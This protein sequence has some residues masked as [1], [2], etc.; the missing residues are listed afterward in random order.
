MGTRNR[1]ETWEE[2]ALGSRASITM[3][4]TTTNIDTTDSGDAT[5]APA[6]DSRPRSTS[7]TPVRR[8]P[9][10]MH[11]GTD[12]PN[13]R[14]VPQSSP[15]DTQ[16]ANNAKPPRLRNSSSSDY[17]DSSH[18]SSDRTRESFVTSPSAFNVI[19]HHSLSAPSSTVNLHNKPTHIITEGTHQIILQKDP[20]SNNY[21]VKHIDEGTFAFYCIRG[22]YTLI[23]ILMSGFLFAFSVQIILFVFLGLLI[24]SGLTDRNQ[25]GFHFIRFICTL[26]ALPYF[27]YGLASAMAMA[28]AFAADTFNGYPLFKA[29]VKEEIA[30]FVDWSS[31][32]V[33]LG[34]PLLTGGVCLCA[35]SSIWWEVTLLTSCTCVFLYF[36]LFAG[37]SIYYEID[38]CLKLQE[39]GGY[40]YCWPKI[41]KAILLRQKQK[42]SGYR[43]ATYTVRSNGDL[44]IPVHDYKELERNEIVN[45][46][47]TIG[48]WARFTKLFVS[49]G[50]YKKLP[51][52]AQVRCFSIDEVLDNLP[53][54]TKHSWG[55]EK[56]FCRNRQLRYV[57]VVSGKSKLTKEQ[58]NSSAAYFFLIAILSLFMMVA[59][60]SWM[61]IGF[62]GYVFAVGVYIYCMW[63]YTAAS[64]RIYKDHTDKVKNVMDKDGELAEAQF[65][66]NEVFL[67]TEP[68]DAFC[69]TQL[70]LKILFLC[71]LPLIAIF[72]A[73]NIPIGIL[74]IFVS[75]ITLL[76]RNIN[77]TTSLLEYGS[78]HSRAI[79]GAP[80]GEDWRQK[81]R[82]Q[83]VVQEISTSS[84][85]G[86]WQNVFTIFIVIFCALFVGA[87]LSPPRQRLDGIKLASNSEYSGATS[88]QY[89]S[90]QLTQGFP[91]LEGTGA[92]LV[93]VAFL[94]TLM[95][96][97]TSAID[98]SLTKWFRD[99]KFIDHSE[100]IAI[101]FKENY[102]QANSASSVTYTL[103]G[104]PEKNIGV[105]TIKGSSSSIDYL[106]DFQLWISAMLTQSVRFTLPM[107][108]LF[109]PVLKYLVFAISRVESDSLEKA[110][111]YKQ[112]TAFVKN[113][114]ERGDLYD[115][116]IITG[117]CKFQ[118]Q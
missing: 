93:D 102:E 30:I 50:V 2:M 56:L 78:L 68:T 9:P 67:W 66:V 64:V 42:L 17:V 117:H 83:K 10:L 77:A 54:V 72:A 21:Y 79:Q 32:L 63:Q 5:G 58:I 98:G 13:D 90:C 81:H 23:T 95:Y 84:K 46:E 71:I 3:S 39:H 34:F 114:T 82:V 12:P 89:P 22:A 40:T 112:T 100:D 31:F 70:W 20:E 92:S 49:C 28:M 36:L 109:T 35:G 61:E 41:K 26:L 107:G 118:T 76:R 57:T 45:S 87:V 105:V 8:S 88:M 60:L 97:K 110:K 111:F 113:I 99:I 14:S 94:A 108:E 74:F 47:S 11:D 53:Y 1:E 106:V 7:C 55:L 27:W 116:I 73:G 80:I 62:L 33:F 52:E 44:P 48:Q 16:M 101:P 43:T 104:F 15:L 51:K 85:T 18:N 65:Q 91:L 59:L 115:H 4:Q 29:Y 19:D 75:I 86:F 38:G 103:I 96:E 25:E 24:E 6:S 37:L 69:W